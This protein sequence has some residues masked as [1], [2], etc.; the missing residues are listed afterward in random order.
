MNK[1][2][3]IKLETILHPLKFL[4]TCQVIHA[5]NGHG[6][7]QLVRAVNLADGLGAL[8]SVL[9]GL[10]YSDD[11]SVLKRNNSRHL[12]T[13]SR[14]LLKLLPKLEL[15]LHGFQG[16]GGLDGPDTSIFR[17]LYSGGGHSGS[18]PQQHVH[19]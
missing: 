5:I 13:I 9:L 15:Q 8:L 17:D 6:V 7:H 10:L 18:L 1:R 2:P 11:L 19:V 4:Y 16:G 3:N 12:A 14:S